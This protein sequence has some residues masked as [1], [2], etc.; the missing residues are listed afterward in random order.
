MFSRALPE[1]QSTLGRPKIV[2]TFRPT[3][4]CNQA[5]TLAD[6]AGQINDGYRKY[7]LTSSSLVE[8]GMDLGD[9]L[10]AAKKKAGHS[11]WYKW[12][13]ANTDISPDRAERFMTL[14]RGRDL[15]L[16]RAQ[17]AAHS[18][19]PPAPPATRKSPPAVKKIPPL[20]SHSWASASFQQRQSFLDDI[21]LQEFLDAAPASWRAEVQRQLRGADAPTESA[22]TNT[23]H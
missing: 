9:I 16:L 3:I 10:I 21:P 7:L 17:R 15:A 6:Y 1:A 13:A 20:D 11:R 5:P 8:Q 2:M 4:G 14:S 23:V 22:P 19:P 12:L 18:S